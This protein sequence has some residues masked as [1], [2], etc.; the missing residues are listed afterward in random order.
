MDL[1][2]ELAGMGLGVVCEGR[3]L[4]NNSAGLRSVEFRRSPLSPEI[5]ARLAEL[6]VPLA[7]W[8]SQPHRNAPA[9]LM[10]VCIR[11]SNTHKAMQKSSK[12]STGTPCLLQSWQVCTA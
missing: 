2:R 11:T 5:S 9:P 6:Q 8:I 10:A 7:F 12:Q 1:L 4:P 3:R